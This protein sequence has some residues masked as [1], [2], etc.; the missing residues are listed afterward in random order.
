MCTNLYCFG[1]KVRLFE[2]D[3]VESA[4]I[5]MLDEGYARRMIFI[6]DNSTPERRTADDIV[7]EMEASE[8]I[9][10]KRK[11]D[12]E[13]I[14]SLITTSNLKKT[15]TMSK[16]LCMHGLLLKLMEIIIY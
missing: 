16:K 15:I 12:R 2:G 7:N 10:E 4:F 1:N 3:N 13:F 8:A 6:D 11:P 9:I 14:K 5:K